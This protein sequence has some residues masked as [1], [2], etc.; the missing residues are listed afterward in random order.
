[1][2]RRGFTLVELLVVIGIIAA[3]VAILLPVIGQSREQAKLITCMN[4]VRQVNHAMLMY[5]ADYDGF[6]P[7]APDP[8]DVWNAKRPPAGYIAYLFQPGTLKLNYEHGAIMP[9]LALSDRASIMRCPNADS[10]YRANYSYVL[11]EDLFQDGHLHHLRN[12]IHPHERILIF[13]ADAPDDGHFNLGGGIDFPSMHHFPGIDRLGKPDGSSNN[14]FADEHVET[15]TRSF[16]LT[17]SNAYGHDLY[18]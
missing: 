12:V 15:L 4:N 5:A 7:I 14:G 2:R 3:L 17:H 1:M 8:T 6:L 10:D 9:Y 18:K 11:N 16:L 13:E